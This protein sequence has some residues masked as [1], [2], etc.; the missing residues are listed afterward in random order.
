MD[1]CIDGGRRNDFQKA[2][3]QGENSFAKEFSP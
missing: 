1:S 3:N 2:D